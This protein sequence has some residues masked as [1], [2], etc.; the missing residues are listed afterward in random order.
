MGKRFRNVP[1]AFFVRIVSLCAAAMQRGSHHRAIIIIVNNGYKGSS[2]VMDGGNFESVSGWETSEACRTGKARIN[3]GKKGRR[4]RN[5]K[6]KRVGDTTSRSI[7][8]T[9]IRRKLKK[10]KVDKRDYKSR[11]LYR[12]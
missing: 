10:D 11:W 9:G 4:R 8:K 5:R 12:E 6:R 1:L 2:W 7:E 3:K